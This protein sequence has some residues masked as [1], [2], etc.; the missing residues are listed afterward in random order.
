MFVQSD[1]R[2]TQWK[3][4]LNCELDINQ[5]VCEFYF[6]ED[7][8]KKCD[9]TVLLDGTVYESP[10]VRWRLERDAVPKSD[11]EQPMT[12]EVSILMELA[13][14]TN[15]NRCSFIFGN[16]MESTNKI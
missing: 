16:N 3:N 10:L 13:A 12:C 6:S 11:Q 8:I 5:F 1:D 14:A 15:L 7:D 4:I 2:R 9:R